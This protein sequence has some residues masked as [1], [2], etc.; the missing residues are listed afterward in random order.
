MLF[1][2]ASV[3]LDYSSFVVVAVTLLWDTTVFVGLLGEILGESS[4]FCMDMNVIFLF[5]YVFTF[6]S[7]LSCEYALFSLPIEPKLKNKN[8]IIGHP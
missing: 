3:S 7:S 8:R 4:F 5:F 2:A 1:P 6:S